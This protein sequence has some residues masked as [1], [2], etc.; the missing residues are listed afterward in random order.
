MEKPKFNIG[1]KVWFARLR[2]VE[3]WDTC[4]DCCG[5]R[6]VTIIFGDGSSASIDCGRCYP[7]GYAVSCGA[8]RRYEWSSDPVECLILGV[9][10]S[11][12]KPIWTYQLESIGRYSADESELFLTKEEADVRAAELAKEQ[13][14][15]ELDR[16]ERRKHD[17]RKTWAWNASY[18]RKCIISAKRDLEYHTKK[19]SVASA[20]ANVPSEES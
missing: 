6:A 16:L 15:E 18:H 3:R 10:R 17:D 9:E 8:V 2:Q 5:K 7:G 11:Q 4:P 13:K 12:F 1:D 19:L 20:K 14:K